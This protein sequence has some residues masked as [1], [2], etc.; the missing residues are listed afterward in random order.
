MGLDCLAYVFI[1]LSSFVAV[2]TL[3][4]L[5][6]IWATR[7]TN[8]E[9]DEAHKYIPKVLLAVLLISVTLIFLLSYYITHS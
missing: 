1:V 5:V 6:L 3:A 7:D 4:I 2:K 8:K 9:E